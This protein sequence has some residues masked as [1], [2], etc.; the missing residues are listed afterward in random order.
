M[1]LNHPYS[2]VFIEEG[3]W[4]H[5]KQTPRANSVNFV[6]K[7]NKKLRTLIYSARV[8]TVRPTGADCAAPRPDRPVAQFGAQHTPI[9]I[10]LLFSLSPR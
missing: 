7:H 5:Y 10:V 2:S 9:T 1:I 6:N 3:G 4:T 8:R